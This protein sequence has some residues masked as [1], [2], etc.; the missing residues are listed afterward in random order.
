VQC[1]LCRNTCPES[2]IR[3]EPRLDLT[4][5]A[6]SPVVLNEEEPFECIRC[7]KPF[8]TR[9]TIERISAQLAGKHSMYQ[10]S[11][12]ADLI[13]MCDNCRIEHQA[14]S[15]NDPFAVGERPR[16]LRT[17]DYLAEEERVRAGEKPTKLTS[18]D[19]LSDDD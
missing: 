11:G 17:E 15:S 16:V 13:R 4:P 10:E 12:A 5:A 7:G 19:F 3:L 1:G 18:D 8:G 9:S 6:L 14:E 2:V